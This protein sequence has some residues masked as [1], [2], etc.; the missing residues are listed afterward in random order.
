MR[1]ELQS[2]NGLLGIGPYPITGQEDAD[3]INAGKETV[4]M[5]PGSATFTSSQSF[6]MIRGGKVE[7][8][9]WQL[10]QPYSTP[11]SRACS[12][13]VRRL[14]SSRCARVPVPPRGIPEGGR[15]RCMRL[16]W[17]LAWH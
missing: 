11:P 15:A 7:Q 9:G 3:N 2:E 17:H 16:G 5:I 13:R 4:T 1:I 10:A 12:W 14:L 8:R 6:A